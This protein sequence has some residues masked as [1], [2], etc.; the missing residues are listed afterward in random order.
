M[1]ISGIQEITKIAPLSNIQYL[2]IRPSRV[3]AQRRSVC[4]RENATVKGLNPTQGKE[5]IWISS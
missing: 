4:L 1:Y 2:E 5:L 3:V